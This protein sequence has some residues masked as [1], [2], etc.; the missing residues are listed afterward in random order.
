MEFSIFSSGKW[1]EYSQEES[2]HSFS[3][4][5]SKQKDKTETRVEKQSK[6]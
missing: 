2:I 4:R 1:K 5:V 3:I 6:E